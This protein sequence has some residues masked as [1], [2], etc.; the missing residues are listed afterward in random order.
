MLDVVVCF[1]ISIIAL[2]FAVYK[3]GSDITELKRKVDILMSLSTSDNQPPYR[4]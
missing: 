2:S 4:G 1:A 3:M